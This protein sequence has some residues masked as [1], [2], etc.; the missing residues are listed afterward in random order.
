[1][2]TFQP[3]DHLH[4]RTFIGLLVAQFF[5]AFNDQ[6]IHAAAMFYAINTA[7]LSEARAIELMPLL[8]YLPWAIFPTVAGYLADRY[9]KQNALVIWKLVEVGITLLALYGFW[10]GRHGDPTA[11]A[12]VVL[13]CVFLMGMHSAFF[14]PAK[15]GVMP[16]ILTPRMLSRGNGILESLSF[17][18]IIAGTVFGGVLSSDL[19]VGGVRLGFRGDEYMIGVILTVLAVIGAVA[20]LMIEKMPAANPTRPFPPYVYQPLYQNVKMLLTSRPLL[21]TVVGLAFFTFLVAYMRQV[22]YM[23]GQ[24]QLPRWSEA[25]TSY[26]VG[27]VALGIGIGSPLVGYLS[28]GKVEI[29]L[30]TIGAVGMMAATSTAAVALFNVPLLVVCIGFIGFF[31]G[32]YLVPLYSLLQHR[33]PK[34]SKGDAVATSNFLNITGAIAA[35]LIFFALN[36]AARQSGFTPPLPA[37]APVEGVLS[38]LEYHDGHPSRVVV[39]DTAF[40]ADE[41]G[42]QVFVYLSVAPDVKKG[43][44]VVARA[45][46]REHEGDG[47]RAKVT[48]VRFQRP[49]AA[50]DPFYDQAKLPS[51][52]FLGAGGL[53]FVILVVLWWLL[54]DLFRRTYLWATM[55]ARLE[56][57]GLLR[58]PGHGP[59]L[60]ATNAATAEERAQVESGL[61]RVTYFLEPGPDPEATARRGKRLLAGGEVVAVSDPGLLRDLMPE[62]ETLPVRQHGFVKNGERRAYVVAGSLLAAGSPEE[63]A[64]AE[65]ARL[66]ERLSAQA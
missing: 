21:F 14:V 40:T 13:A 39:G 16:E 11:G 66:G 9:S 34:Q 53:T 15:Y 2:K 49:G 54:P 43:E 33:A 45:Y 17:I 25:Y 56:T 47:I 1:M 60:I 27:V 22:V 52:L 31:T 36:Q 51:L 7:V 8:F 24:S 50:E 20:S 6:A 46:V 42:P 19:V 35:S 10:L 63:M 37:L 65:L 23:H 29:G 59:T 18:A 64:T 58:L 3:A 44:P 32:F 28:G 62:A 30:V 12:W 61:D 57:A 38:E 55:R 48:K 4:S 5:A 41:K 26:I